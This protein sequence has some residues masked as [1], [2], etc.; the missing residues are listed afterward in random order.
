LDVVENPTGNAT[1][2]WGLIGT[3]PP[4]PTSSTAPLSLALTL[5]F[6]RSEAFNLLLAIAT[7][8][9]GNVWLADFGKDGVTEIPKGI[10]EKSNPD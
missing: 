2:L 3:T 9:S 5:Q 1:T 8:P 4:Y 7:D 10:R 6:T